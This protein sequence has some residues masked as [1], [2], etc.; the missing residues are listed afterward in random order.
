[1]NSFSLYNRKET[2]EVKIGNV[3]IGGNNPILIQSMCN[4]DTNDVDSTVKQ[5]LD[6]EK[7]GVEI[8]RVA[9]KDVETANKIYDI[10]NKINIPL[11]CDVH[12]DYKIALRCMEMGADKI[13]I[14]PGN[15][16][17][18]E[19]TKKVVKMAK[20]KN[21]PIR[22]GVNSGSISKEI[23][24]EF[25]GVTPSAIVKSAMSHVKILEDLDF[26]D[27][28]ISIKASSVPFTI[29]A[30]EEISTLV[31]YPLHLGI[32]ESGTLKGGTIKSSVGIG[33]ILSRGIGDTIRVSLTSDPI[34]EVYVA[35]DI[36]SSMEI[37]SFG[38]SIISCP[39]CGRTEIDLIKIANQ[40]EEI[41]KG[42]KKDIKIAVMG[43][44]VNG[45]G[46]A[47]QCDIGIAGGK[48]EGLIFKN[49][50]IIKKVK[51]HELLNALLEEIETL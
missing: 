5:I 20:E 44:V 6:L 37:R 26:S 17:S 32:T 7:A 33:S 15:I 10:K 4:T 14:N 38:A 11:V 45:P 51:E 43:C 23:I 41:A 30:Y 3:K 25:S 34:D 28:I 21:I 12:F 36:L 18:I 22:I 50:V 47:K 8:I 40:V 39:T 9:V 16:G 31:K 1:M 48:G 29:E 24:E 19:N 49:G 42:I 27:I 13:R 35:K 46:E 2:N